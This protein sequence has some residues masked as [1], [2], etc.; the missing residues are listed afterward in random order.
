MARRVL[1]AVAAVVAV[2]AVAPSQALPGDEMTFRGTVVVG[3]PGNFF[4][5]G[6]SA[7]A[8]CD[9]GGT[10]DGADGAWLTVPPHV[11]GHRATLEYSSL[12]AADM[13]AYF[14]GQFCGLIPYWEMAQNPENTPEHGYV[15]P[16]AK[17]V[18]LVANAGVS[19]AFTFTIHR[20]ITPEKPGRSVP[21]YDEVAIETA[22]VPM[23]DGATI[24]VEVMRPKTPVGVRVPVIL[25]FSPYN[26]GIS[27]LPPDVPTGGLV[28]SDPYALDE[29]FVPRG[30]ARAYADLRGTRESG[31]CWDYGGILER[32]DASD[33]VD[34][35]GTR[36]WSNG[37]VGMIGI[38]YEGTTANAALAERSR[39]L[40]TIVPI[41]S[42]D[43]WYDYAYMNGVRWFLNSENSLQ[44]G[45]DTPAYF[46]WGDL[47]LVP[48]LD[49][50]SNAWSNVMAERY[51]ECFQKLEHTERGYDLQPDYD[52]FWR[53]RDYRALAAGVRVP[54]LI[55]HGLD[56]YNVKSTGSTEMYRLLSGPK[57]MLL[58]QWT[59]SYAFATRSLMW[60]YLLWRWFDQWLLGIDT[61]VMMEPPVI[62]QD[63]ASTW[64]NEESWRPPRTA[65]RVMWLTG[66]RH[67]SPSPAGPGSAAWSDVDPTASEDRMMN[68]TSTGSLLF[69]GDPVEKATRIAGSPRV[70]LRLST[71]AP[72]TH[73]SVFLA[74]LDSNGS[75]QRISRGLM[76]PR[77]RRGLE[78]G[79]DLVPGEEYTVAF[80]L[81]PTDHVVARG[82][83]IALALSSSNAFWAVPDERRAT[84]TLY[85]GPDTR[86]MLPVVG[87][88]KVRGGSTT[89]SPPPPRQ[90]APLPATGLPRGS[91][92]LGLIAA[93]MAVA[94]CLRPWNRTGGPAGL[95]IGRERHRC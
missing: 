45:F 93:S 34:W 40:A 94:I 86:I 36:P 25:T 55:V 53:D 72:S 38:S 9:P 92:G 79:E 42:I 91:W 7:S 32:R 13:D 74:E 64:H 95:S 76:N 27:Y 6:V 56:D 37:K 58:G 67:L 73:L 78:R 21:L 80:D 81:L 26:T 87:A 43:R 51:T 41:A 49:A 60:S 84:N 52:Q 15:H 30:Y 68:G 2:L 11:H 20:D 89:Q 5:Y 54:A 22:R 17:F 82:H 19:V 61:G 90:S 1:A 88:E 75:W 16:G 18:L 12:G 69:V 23:R 29:F 10:L 46:D 65:A 63:S 44:Q 57:R 85:F 4:P 59:H 70:E 8:P 71:D 66:A 62:T 14:Y 47:T 39:H 83:R 48:P 35:L 33:I 50:R 28:N 31:G 77:Y 24:Y 3:Q